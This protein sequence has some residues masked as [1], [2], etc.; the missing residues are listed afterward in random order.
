MQ[1]LH[2]SSTPL[3]GNALYKRHFFCNFMHYIFL[4]VATL[5]FL[6]PF[7]VQPQEPVQTPA[8]KPTEPSKEVN[9]V[10]VLLTA[11]T[12]AERESLLA[13]NPA[14]VN[15]ELQKALLDEGRRLRAQA[16]FSPALAALR[17]A[18][19]VARQRDDQIGVALAL[20]QV[21][22]IYLTIRQYPEALQAFQESLKTR[23]KVGDKKTVAESLLDLGSCYYRLDNYR[24]A[25]KYLRQ[26]LVLSEESKDQAALAAT[27]STMANVERAQGKY[28]E[29]LQ[30]FRESLRLSEGSTEQ[31]A[32]PRALFG[33]GSTQHF[34]G[35][36]EEAQKSLEQSLKLSEAQ[37]NKAGMSFALNSLGSI[38]YNKSDYRLAMNRFHQS[39]ELK[40]VL[41]DKAGAGST[42]NNMGLVLHLQGDDEQ[43]LDYYQKSLRLAEESHFNS[44]IPGIRNNI[45]NI[46]RDQ[47]NYADALQSYQASL[48]LSRQ[49]GRQHEI[50]LTLSNIGQVYARQGN[51][52]LALPQLQES[53]KLMEAIGNQGGIAGILSDLGELYVAQHDYPKALELTARATTIARQIGDLETLWKT[54]AN[55][56]RV[57]RTLGQIEAARQAFDEA[58][59]IIETLRLQVA[60]GEV[61][62]QQ[63]FAN[64]SVPYSELVSLGIASSD[65]PQAL[66]YAERAKARTLLDVLHSGRINITKAMNPAEQGQERTIKDEL[67]SLNSQLARENARPHPDAEHLAQL[68]ANLKQARLAQSAFQTK[69]YAAHPALKIQRGLIPAFSLEQ[70]A[71]LIPDAQTALVEYVVTEQKTLMFVLTGEKKTR[72]EG[73][74]S[75]CTLKVYE[76]P[77]TSLKLS[78]LVNDYRQR[79]AQHNLVFREAATQL[80][81]LLIRPAAAQLQGVKTLVIVPDSS[82]WELP[83][84]ALQSQAKATAEPHYL[85]EDYALFYAPSLAVLAEMVKARKQ[86]SGHRQTATL[87]AFGNPAAGREPGLARGGNNLQLPEAAK[88]VNNLGQLYGRNES[89]VF[90]GEAASEEQFKAAAGQ[91]RVL[92]LATHGLL[93]NASPMYSQIILAL[94]QQSSK[95]DGTLEAWEIMQMELTAELVVLSAC[96]TARGRISGGEGVIGLSWALFVAGSPATVVSQWKI[97]SASTTELMLGFHRQLKANPVA[98]LAAKAQALQSAA[99][100]LL[101]SQQ[102]RHPFYWAGFV[103]IGDGY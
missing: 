3:V 49:L 43:A 101:H 2:N 28:N 33:I 56:G 71:K 97:D 75:V 103:V 32:R 45:A 68:N 92:H 20:R 74:P 21:G 62:Q 44:L 82:L 52:E 6:S 70:A 13:N 94:P 53:L 78:E 26:A 17:L 14:L 64:K 84:Q 77:V 83:F 38:A 48:A 30:Y 69:L 11:K 36:F 12:E 72:A 23:E 91:Y 60:G 1:P 90:T 19:K 9:F 41:N 57:Y 27:F 86:K 93:N 37:N 24:A 15:S 51:Y 50:A 16:N 99:L 95:E 18:E 25:M 39:L 7:S 63:F 88:E 66:A 98:P 31:E 47:G 61:S 59:T 29:A 35:N 22:N 54:R 10:H 65:L 4:S 76:L 40:Q 42:M 85:I 96:E 79:L 80:F 89:Q 58:I 46:Y 67:V 55:A 8:S 100:Q 102:Y 5:F 34:L 87:L 81:D 73:A